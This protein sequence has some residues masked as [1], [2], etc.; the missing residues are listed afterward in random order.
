MEETPTIPLEDPRPTPIPEGY[1]L[2]GI[3]RN[4]CYSETSFV[5]TMCA[6]MVMSI[7]ASRAGTLACARAYVCIYIYFYA[8]IHVYIYIHTY[9]FNMCTY[10]SIYVYASM[11]WY[12]CIYWYICMCVCVHI[13]LPAWLCASVFMKRNLC[14]QET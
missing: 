7:W 8:Y 11:Y 12:I 14:I 1:L 10:L 2:L 5:E 3:F 13:C 4:C 6:I 9:S